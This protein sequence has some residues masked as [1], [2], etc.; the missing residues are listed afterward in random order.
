WD[1]ATLDA[2]LTSPAKF[3]KG[4]K[5]TFA[6]IADAQQRADVIAYMKTKK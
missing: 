6:G 1:D 2:W 3:A 5:M 4:T